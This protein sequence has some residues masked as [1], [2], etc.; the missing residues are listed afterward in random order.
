MIYVIDGRT[1]DL[2]QVDL[3]FLTA[4]D[5]VYFITDRD[6][7]RAGLFATLE[8][9]AKMGGVF[10]ENGAC[11]VG[12]DGKSH[13]VKLQLLSSLIADLEMVIE[14]SNYPIHLGQNL[15]IENHRVYVS[16]V[17][18]GASSAQEYAYSLWEKQKNVRSR[19]VSLLQPQ[20]LDYQFEVKGPASLT[21]SN[22]AG[23]FPSMLERIQKNIGEDVRISYVTALAEETVSLKYF[24]QKFQAHGCHVLVVSSDGGVGPLE[25]EDQGAFEQRA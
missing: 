6:K 14:Q 12:A 20:Y 22:I 16:M 1:I 23:F 4:D 17:G 18:L 24:R 3:N 9:S 25:D 2:N 8:T 11:F 5:Q 7:Y 19:L 13:I 10:Y 15:L 21:L